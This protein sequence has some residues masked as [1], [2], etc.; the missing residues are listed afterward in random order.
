[1]T[2]NYYCDLDTD[3]GPDEV[4]ARL[5]A[6]MGGT[7]DTGGTVLRVRTGALD[8]RIITETDPDVR[9]W[10]VEDWGL[11]SKISIGFT[12]D[13]SAPESEQEAGRRNFSV[14][15]AE[16]GE[17][18]NAD[19]ILRFEGNRLM[20]RRR[21]GALTLYDWWPDWTRPEVIARLPTGYTLGSDGQDAP[22]ERADGT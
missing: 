22:E 6:S 1:V 9:E 4:A 18:L 20:M 5:R 13:E 17:N 21:N 3:A 7:I 19:A 8:A 11:D 14:A 16:L 15:S 10:F 2:T 12:V